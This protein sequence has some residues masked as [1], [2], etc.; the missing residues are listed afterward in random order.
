MVKRILYT[1]I[2]IIAFSGFS[3]EEIQSPLLS[4]KDIHSNNW[5]VYKDVQD[6]KIEYKF[7]ACDFDSG[8]D[9]ELLL[10]KI[11]NKTEGNLGI[12]WFIHL[13]YGED[14]STCDFP[15]EY[16][17]AINLKPNEII[18]GDCSMDNNH[19]LRIFYKFVDPKFANKSKALN[20]FKLS[21]LTFSL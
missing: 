2:I 21:N 19:P 3:Q 14:C 15:A 4:V 8:L 18:E 11:T 7:E 1:L 16:L 10:L 5:Q 6:F 9:E 13:Y 20:K 12:D 17:R